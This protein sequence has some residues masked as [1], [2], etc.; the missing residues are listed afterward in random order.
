MCTIGIEKLLGDFYGS[1]KNE[2][3]SESI[4]HE[5]LY[6]KYV[7][8]ETQNALNE[9]SLNDFYSSPCYPDGWSGSIQLF[10][11]VYNRI[12]IYF[13]STTDLRQYVKELVADS[14]FKELV[15]VAFYIESTIS[16]RD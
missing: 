8:V 1:L 15:K 10:V 5:Q 13:Y 16:P 3:Q 14:N 2:Y 7:K 12:E 6:K 4:D 11:N 9:K